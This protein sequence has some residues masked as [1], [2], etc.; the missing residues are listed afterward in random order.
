[1]TNQDAPSGIISFLRHNISALIA[2]ACDFLVL[3]FLTEVLSFWYMASTALGAITGAIIAFLLGRNW[4]FVAKEERKRYQAIRYFVVACGSVLLN[5]GGVYLLT[6]FL[7]LLYTTSKII[8]GVSVGL[9]YNYPMGKYFVFRRSLPS[10]K[11]KN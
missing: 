2:S 8:T 4:A 3:V 5:L 9:A 7:G 10:G 6:D 1:M 11:V